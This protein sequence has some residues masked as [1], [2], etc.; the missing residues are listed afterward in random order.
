MCGSSSGTSSSVYNASVFTK[1]E[2]VPPD[3][4]ILRMEIVPPAIDPL[5]PKNT[6]F[7]VCFRNG[8]QSNGEGQ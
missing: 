3:L 8:L 7:Q 2:F 4:R 1:E 5:S 6:P